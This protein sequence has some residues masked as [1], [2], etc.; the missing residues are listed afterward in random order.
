M[1]EY[2]CKIGLF[3]IEWFVLFYRKFMIN[4][5]VCWVWYS[6]EF[7]NSLVV[8]FYNIL[9]IL[10]DKMLFRLFIIFLVDRNNLNILLILVC[11]FDKY[12]DEM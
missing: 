8:C 12:F 10:L 6:K 4:F 9:Y 7:M 3:D 2:V 5:N 1:V 11:E